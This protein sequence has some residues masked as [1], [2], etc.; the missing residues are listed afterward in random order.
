MADAFTDTSAL[1]SDQA[2]YAQ[3]AMFAFRPALFFDAL[4]QVK[5]TN[6]GPDRGSSA[7]FT[8]YTEMSAATTPLTETSDIDAVAVGDSQVTVTPAEHG[9]TVVRTAK[10]AATSFLDV[11]QDIANLIGYN[12][13]LTID[14]LAQTALAGG[15]NVYYG[16]GGA[17]T[18]TS[19]TTVAVED[20]AATYDVTLMRAKLAGADVPGISAGTMEGGNGAG[21]GTNYVG[22]IHPDVRFDLLQE[23]AVNTWVAAEVYRNPTTGSL[24][25]GEVGMYAGI[26]WIETSRAPLWAN[27]SNGSGSTGTIDV[28]GAL[29]VGWQALGKAYSDAGG[30]GTQ[31]VFVLNEG[32]DRLR[33]FRYYGWKHF[34]GYGRIREA[35]LRRLEA[36]SSIGANT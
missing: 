19:R 22:V 2:A 33:R 12:A 16:T 32:L 27:A 29:A 25:T 14:T 21:I 28:Y 35:A 7:K 4:A 18:P 9:N 36:A 17:S 23:T 1:L 5:P 34:V 3:Y 6:M 31:P 30:Y 24:F 13:A 15:S 11:E 26:R 8:I 10:V 20:V